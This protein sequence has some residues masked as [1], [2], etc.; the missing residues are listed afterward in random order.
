MSSP[1]E[2]Q[3][4][5]STPAAPEPPPASQAPPTGQQPPGPPPAGPVAAVPPV[6]YQ[7]PATDPFAPV[8]R[9]PRSPW[10]APQRKGAVIGISIVAAFALIGGGIGIGAAAFGSDDHGGPGHRIERPGYGQGQ[11]P[12]NPGFPGGPRNRMQPPANPA[13]ATPTPAPSTTS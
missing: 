1:D 7:Y 11:L 2:P 6:P 9:P 3:P 5:E 12:G 8:Q 4:N 10:I 13:P